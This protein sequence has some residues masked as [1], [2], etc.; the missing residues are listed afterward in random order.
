MK[1]VTKLLI[2]LGFENFPL[3]IVFNRFH[4]PVSHLIN[5]A[6]RLIHVIRGANCAFSKTTLKI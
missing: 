4:E 2:I 5:V 6:Q 1:T 3:N